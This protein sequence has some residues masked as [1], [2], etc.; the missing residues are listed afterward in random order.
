VRALEAV[1]AIDALDIEVPML[2]AE[3]HTAAP[4]E[5]AALVRNH[6]QA[7]TER[8]ALTES[9]RIAYPVV[10]RR[11]A[12]ALASAAD[13]ILD[14][15]QPLWD[16]TAEEF[17]T[18]LRALPASVSRGKQVSLSGLTADDVHVWQRAET[19]RRELDALSSLRA[20]L[21]KKVRAD[22]SIEK[23]TRVCRP[24]DYGHFWR[25]SR[26]AVAGQSEAFGI[27]GYYVNHGAELWW[28]SVSEQGSL[29]ASLNAD[30]VHWKPGV[31]G[32][33]RKRAS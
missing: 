24:T 11:A 3:L 26:D 20:S 13:S 15:L 29:I 22:Q 8:E 33:E 7:V 27:V 9:K 30:A 28:P 19:S 18:A 2:E 23:I 4:E 10:A 16:N 14:A 1:E 31:A 25:L 6:A 32:L 17:T 12:G 21:P 5:A